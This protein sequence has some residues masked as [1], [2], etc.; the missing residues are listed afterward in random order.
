[1]VSLLFD[2]PQVWAYAV[3][4]GL[5]EDPRRVEALGPALAMAA[6]ADS[7]RVARDGGR[8][9]IEVPKPPDKRQPLRPDR[10]EALTA[11]QLD[12]RA[13]GPGLERPARVV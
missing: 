3:S 9:L 4:L 11:A 2:G 7:A 6:G 5:G 12:G 10:L 13:P 1:M 8:L